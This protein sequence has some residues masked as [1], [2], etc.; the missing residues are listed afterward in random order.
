MGDTRDLTTGSPAAQLV[1]LAAP[2]LLGNILQQL[3]NAVDAFVIGRYAGEL[4]FAAV[5][6]AGSVM[7]LFLFAVVGACT[8]ISVLFAQFCGAGDLPSLRREHFLSLTAGTLCA[9][10]GSAAGI[11][12]VPVLLE[13]IRTPGNVAGYAA[14]YLSIVLAGLPAAFVYNLYSAL[15]RAVGRTRAVLLALALSAGTNLG[16]DLLL[17]AGL[18]MGVR[19]AAWATVASECLSALLCGIYLRRVTPQLLF[20]REDCRMDAALLRRTARFG[21]TTGLHQ[22]GLYIGK[23]LVQG[24][25]NTGGT[26]II[27]AYTAATRIEGFANSFGDSGAAATSVLVAQNYG[28]GKDERVRQSFRCSLLLLFLMGL[29]STLVMYATAEPAVSLMLGADSGPAF[30]QSVS[31]M[32]TVALFYTLCFVGNT[33]AGYFDGCGRVS[34]PLAG[35]VGHI[36]VRVVLSWLLVGSMGLNAVAVATGVGWC[37]MN[38]FWGLCFRRFHPGAPGW[39]REPQLFRPAGGGVPVS[40]QS[41]GQEC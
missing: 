21:L 27:S 15:L 7:N 10:L 23:L 20:H 29:A 12:A 39:R 8:G 19:G 11:A 26:E 16:L 25:V 28:A 33:L 31:Y 18:G 32:K 14:D 40:R 22:S 13:L 17:V 41:R 6:V 30:A 24:A 38:V 3:Y 4:E 35:A 9:A 34:I 1:W 2:L 36:T 37:L 5:G